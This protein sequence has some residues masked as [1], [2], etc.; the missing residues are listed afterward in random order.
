MQMKTIGV[1][2]ERLGVG[3]RAY[4]GLHLAR[5][6]ALSVWAEDSWIGD[7]GRNLYAET[8][9]G[10]ALYAVWAFG[11]MFAVEWSPKI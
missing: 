9:S 4:E 6:G 2:L 7:A 3:V 5:I 11:R 8:R 1:E 10:Y